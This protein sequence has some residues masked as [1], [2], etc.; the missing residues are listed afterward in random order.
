MLRIVAVRIDAVADLDRPVAVVV[1][2][3]L[4]PEPGAGALERVLVAVRVGDRDEPQLVVLEQ[5]LDLLVVRPPGG[6]V[7]V[8]Q[9]PV[10]L[11]GDPLPR[12]LQRAVEHR[13]PRAVGDLAGALGELERDDLAALSG[14]ADDHG[15][16]ELR[17]PARDVVEVGA[18]AVGTV[19]VA[20]DV[21]SGCQLLRGRLAGA[22]ALGVLAQRDVHLVGAELPHLRAGQHEVDLHA[23]VG[24]VLRGDDVVAPAEQVV[25]DVG[26][27]G[28]LV[29][30]E[31][32]AA[33]L[34]RRRRPRECEQRAGDAAEKHQALHGP[35]M[36]MRPPSRG[37]AG[38]PSTE[39]GR[40][41]SV[42]VERLR[43]RNV[44]GPTRVLARGRYSAAQS[45]RSGGSAT[46]QEGMDVQR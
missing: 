28:D 11:A 5:A 40:S 21:E 3:R 16:G 17:V 13:R 35:P 30:V 34:R 18:H 15:L 1:A 36:R 10:H 19:V 14:P 12:V 24:E 42:G 46:S 38:E 6:D 7:V 41:A 22:E 31:R 2:Q 9:T 26:L 4:A 33:R 32:E 25:V 43:A 44:T 20:P 23:A 29:L 27:D 8:D 39:R 37:E 45:R